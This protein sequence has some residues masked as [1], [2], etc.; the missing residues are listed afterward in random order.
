LDQR[1]SYLEVEKMRD[2]Q[3]ILQQRLGPLEEEAMRIIW[4]LATVQGKVKHVAIEVEEKL[5]SLNVQGAEA[6][7]QIEA[8]IIK[9]VE[10]TKA[11][12]QNFVAAWKRRKQVRVALNEPY[13]SVVRPLD[14]HSWNIVLRKILST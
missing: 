1:K 2:Q 10:V 11:T 7:T 13:V 12:S 9:E 4:E 5:K 14:R 6:I 8:M 3:T